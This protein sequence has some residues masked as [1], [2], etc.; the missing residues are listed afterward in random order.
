[1]FDSHCHPTDIDDPL[2]VVQQALAHGVTSLLCCGYHQASNASVLELRRRVPRL[3]ITLGLHPWF[4]NEP[5]SEIAAMVLSERPTAIGECGLDGE[6]RDPDIPPLESQ[7]ATFERQLD[8]A[9]RLGLPLTVHSRKAV[10]EVVEMAQHFPNVRGVLHAYSGSI[11]QIRPLLERGWMIGVGGAV[12]RPN[13]RRIRKL[14]TQ[15]DSSQLLLETDAPA[16]GLE[17]VR[18]P[19]VRPFHVV[20]V[21]RVLAGLR[22]LD[23]G[24][25]VAITDANA[26]R[27][28]GDQISNRLEMASG[29]ASG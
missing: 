17:D 21:A 12:T 16:I 24:E 19:W 29:A 23:P 14:A 20:E 18:P 22:G 4:V 10:N 15:V 25:I 3:P 13:A 2:A 28:F 6:V 9:Q 8:L 5:W 26:R 1:M 7:R 27:M 11:E